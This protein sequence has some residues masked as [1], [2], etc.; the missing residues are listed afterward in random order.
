MLANKATIM[1]H[2]IVLRRQFF[3]L[4]NHNN[5]GK[6]LFSYIKG[7]KLY[8][9]PP[10]SILVFDILVPPNNIHALHASVTSRIGFKVSLSEF[11]I[12]FIQTNPNLNL[13]YT[14]SNMNLN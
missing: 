5:L 2:G 10:N 6:V 8:Q 11:D 4:K 12:S 9:L 3:T 14:N 13:T 1:K 7:V